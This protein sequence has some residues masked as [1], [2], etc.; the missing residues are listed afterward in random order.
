MMLLLY[1]VQHFPSVPSRWLKVI[2]SVSIGPS[3][4]LQARGI[5]L[6]DAP[7]SSEVQ[8]ARCFAS[9]HA[10]VTYYFG[11]LDTTVTL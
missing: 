4:I 9:V 11:K 7:V 5:C 6:T 8:A 2:R 3:A 1:L 10:N